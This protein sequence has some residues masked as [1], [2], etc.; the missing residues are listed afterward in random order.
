MFR[1][2]K[3]GMGNEAVADH[4]ISIVLLCLRA[5]RVSSKALMLQCSHNKVLTSESAS[6]IVLEF[7]LIP[8]V[9]E[10]PDIDLQPRYPSRY[11][12]H[13]FAKTA[14]FNFDFWHQ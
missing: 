6:N 14:K 13:R 11:I 8:I 9:P 10:L 5:S 1:M 2:K 3:M 7:N 4:G 12:A